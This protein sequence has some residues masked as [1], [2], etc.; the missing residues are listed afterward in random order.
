M[1]VCYLILAHKNAKQL[2]MLI[3]RLLI[4]KS[5]VVYLHISIPQYYDIEPLI[6]K[7]NRVHIIKNPIDVEW[8]G[9][10]ILRAQ[11]LLLN[12]SINENA[13]IYQFLTGQDFPIK[14]N[15]TDFY[16]EHKNEV[17]MDW[18]LSPV[19]EKVRL[20]YKWPYVL[21]KLY[22][23]KTNIFR[24]IRKIRYTLLGL[25][26]PGIKKRMP[27]KYRKI[28][29]YKSMFWVTLDNE[30]A[31]YVVDYLKYNNDYF[32]VYQNALNAEEGFWATTIMNNN[33]L[34]SK[35]LSR[36]TL[37]YTSEFVNNHPKTFGIDDY[38]VLMKSDCL[39]A[40]KFD[41]DYD[42]DI[43]NRFIIKEIKNDR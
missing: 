6:E 7:N 37:V 15:L 43:L 4:E 27:N 9:D 21:S 39:F 13:D 14:S 41:I 16:E 2:N 18:E 26:F 11:L 32:S 42:K 36:R 34:S 33:N 30:T 38:N 35:I 24:I 17:F 10:N 19:E 22:N 31:K 40:R 8:G 1:K 25:G 5:S 23:K 12:E 28:T 20:M 3:S 29:L